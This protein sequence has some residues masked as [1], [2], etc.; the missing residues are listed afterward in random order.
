MSNTNVEIKRNPNENSAN[1][2]RR[3]QKKIQESGILQKVR[4]VRYNERKLSD[5]KVKKAKLIKLEGKK[6]Y[7]RLKKLGKLVE[8][9]RR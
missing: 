4:G 2:L 5:L 3:F 8:K 9:K 6:E 1:V 7:D